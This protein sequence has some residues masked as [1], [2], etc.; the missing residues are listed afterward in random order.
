[1]RNKYL[2]LIAACCVSLGLL[3]P[4]QAKEN[5][6]TRA[7]V[8]LQQAA[9]LLQQQRV[10]EA[11]PLVEGV[12]KTYRAQYGKTAEKIYTARWQTEALAYVAEAAHHQQKAT[13]I[14]AVWSDAFYVQGYALIEQG[15]LDA[16]AAAL[17]EALALAPYNAHYL[18]ERA[19]VELLRKDWAAARSRFADAATAAESYSPPELQTAEL[20]RAWRGLGYVAVEEGDLDAAE[21]FYRR[22]LQRDANDQR[23]AAE[24]DFVLKLKQR[25]K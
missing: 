17:D 6:T 2:Q 12:L 11:L 24:L 13:V 21:R 9:T 8:Q 7:M 16:A 10:A 15:K 25:L 14:E 18:N 1:M 22:C 4:V 20:T 5:P 3:L 23:A 19:T